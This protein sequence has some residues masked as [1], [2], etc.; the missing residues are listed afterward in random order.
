MKLANRISRLFMSPL[1]RAIRNGMQVGEGVSVMGGVN[2]GSEP[3]LISLGNHVRVSNN[4]VFINHDGG[5]WA[6]RNSEKKYENVIKFGVIKIGDYSFVGSN[7]IIMPGV[8][9]G[10]NCVIGAGSVV[11][12][13]FPDNSVLCGVP[14]KRIC[15]TEEYAEKCLSHMPPGFDAEEYA[16]NKKAYLLSLLDN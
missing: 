9:I 5:T 12:R 13:D 10:K 15:S 16:K 3:Y 4:V 2:F 8:H 1:K 7:A 14:A 6:F 11:T